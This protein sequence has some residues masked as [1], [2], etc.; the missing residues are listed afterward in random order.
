MAYIHSCN[1]L[2][3][4]SISRGFAI[5]SFIPALFASITSSVNAF[6]VIAT[7]GN[8]SPLCLGRERIAV[9]A[10]YPLDV[11]KRQDVGHLLG[12]ASIEIWITE[13]DISRKLVFSGDIGN[14]NQPLIKDPQTTSSAD[15][16]I[17]E[18]TYGDRLHKA[19]PDYAV[20]LA[21]VIN[22]TLRRGGNLVIP[23][24][25]VGQMCIRD[26]S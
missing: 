3:N 15:Y 8:S 26:S 19:P 24:F 9:A 5:C 13:N 7:I 18:S 22:R 2:F 17:M 23:A 10:S 11:Y 20:E 25:A 16:V 14:I 4:F 1:I 12:S 6:A 21:N